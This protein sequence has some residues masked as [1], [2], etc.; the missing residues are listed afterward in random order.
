MRKQCWGLGLVL[1]LTSIV[2]FACQPQETET[3][4]PGS[5]TSPLHS[6]LPDAPAV[7][8]TAMVDSSP[9]YVYTIDTPLVP[10]QTQV[11]GSG[12]EDIPI[13]IVDVTSMGAELGAGFIGQDGRFSIEVLPLPAGHRIGIM[14]G[15]VTDP[16]K[17]FELQRYGQ[18]LPMVGI[19]LTSTMSLEE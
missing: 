2:V 4:A 6:P 15:T 8:L 5:S 14:L 19:I 13:R 1:L 10:G 3:V 9:I 12:P 11:S 16:D 18:D 7:E 17:S